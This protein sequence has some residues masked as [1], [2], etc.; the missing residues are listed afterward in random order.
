M[1]E[2]EI[3]IIQ[4]RDFG[5]Q[6][7]SGSCNSYVKVY[8]VP[9]SAKLMKR[10]TKTVQRTFDPVFEQMFI[11]TMQKEFIKQKDLLIVVS[12]HEVLKK[13]KYIGEIRIPLEVIPSTKTY[14]WSKLEIKSDK[15]KN[16]KIGTSQ[17]QNLSNQEIKG[18][19]LEGNEL[20]LKNLE[21]Q[22]SNQISS[23]I[24]K[25][26]PLNN[27]S[28]KQLGVLKPSLSSSIESISLP[29]TNDFSFSRS[30]EDPIG[31]IIISLRFETVNNLNDMVFIKIHTAEIF[32]SN[33]QDLPN[34]FVQIL[35]MNETIKEHK[36][37]TRIIPFSKNPNFEEIFN[38]PIRRSE[39]LSMFFHVLDFFNFIDYFFFFNFT[40]FFYHFI[41]G[42]VN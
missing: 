21:D 3:V 33:T 38:F 29:E 22:E 2:L 9:D 5:P 12:H 26:E 37:K 7:D 4:G 19:Q 1:I 18:N 31:K 40:T 27:F 6:N 8:I 15:N 13:G 42:Y 32:T 36:L 10:K 23:R 28:I 41:L 16:N 17:E 39:R 11:I 24:E 14:F 30:N 25:Q 35:L 34:C 20:L